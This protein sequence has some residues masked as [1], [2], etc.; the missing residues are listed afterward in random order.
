MGGV[1]RARDTCLDRT[2]AVKILPAH[3]S[4]DPARKLRFE[5]EAKTVSALDHPNICSLFDVG[6]QD[7][8]DFPMMDQRAGSDPG[9]A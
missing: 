6:S 8:I 3:F 1:Y 9:H 7:G 4:P 5:R 2:V